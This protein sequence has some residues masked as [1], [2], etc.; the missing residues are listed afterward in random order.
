[1]YLRGKEYKDMFAPNKIFMR[2]IV[3][4]VAALLL[5][6]CSAASTSDGTTPPNA[7]GPAVSAITVTAT[8]DS[9]NF[10]QTSTIRATVYDSS[11]GPVSGVSLVFALDQP[12][13]AFITPA[14]A[15][16]DATGLAT[17]TLT[18]RSQQ[19][20]VNVSAT[21]GT[22]T[23]ANRQVAIQSGVT[24]ATVNVTADPSTILIGAT[25]AIRAE[26]L[27]ST[28]AWVPNGT[29]VS[30][31][32]ANPTFGSMAVA[33][34]TTVSGVATA[35]FEAG[36]TPGNAAINV[37]S[38]GITNSV[39]VLINQTAPASLEFI[40]A[41]PGLIAIQGSGG[42][43]TAVVAFRVND[44]N[45]NPIPSIGVSMTLEGPGGGAYI[46]NDGTPNQINVSSNALGIAQATLRSGTVAGPATILAEITVGGVV[47]RVRSSVVS[48]GGGVPSA[49]RF[50]VAATRLNL[51]ALDKNN[52]T[53][54][55]TAYMADRFGNYNILEGT[56]VSFYS[57]PA[58]AIDTAGSVLV[59]A[60]GTAT[61][62]ARTQHPNQPAYPV[63]GGYDVGP[64]AWET[65]LLGYVNEWYGWTARVQAERGW[66]GDNTPR[67]G[68]VSVLVVTDG[69]EH[70]DDLNANG[71]YDAGIDQM[72]DTFDDPFIDYNDD[73][74]LAQNT[75]YTSSGSDP[76]EMFVD[77]NQNGTWDHKNNVWDSDK[78]IFHNFK[79][80]ITGEPEILI[81][82]V[83]EDPDTL[84]QSC[85][86]SLFNV[87]DGADPDLRAGYKR[88]RFLVADM[89]LNYPSAG[90]KVSAS[91]DKGKLL[92]EKITFEDSSEVPGKI[93][94]YAT[95]LDDDP[96]DADP[97][98][99][100][101]F[102][103][104]VEWE[105]KKIEKSIF[106]YI[107]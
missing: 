8:P 76:I 33:A 81:C 23:S 107:D 2:Q 55:V 59:G 13:L 73:I 36:S 96:G 34:A 77:A 28:G 25:S 30:F 91:A 24:A 90:T 10:S 98:K 5:L 63:P 84:V 99:L 48:I 104:T 64:E 82:P 65:T 101:E 89:N 49:G 41:T 9:V 27:D 68:L 95:L 6:G 62:T 21:D 42:V 100:V 70:F 85:E 53:T 37:S 61:V 72:V 44:Q 86:T 80:L 67:D 92:S 66:A 4:I 16:T 15:T 17:A 56:T 51:P 94:Y 105:G 50:S 69:E 22:T 26:V 32:V 78:K 93:E 79:I 52:V 60:D 106:G 88:F 1:M 3:A 58:L 20:N 38:G 46:D 57:E 14:I 39:D 43:E 18:A 31:A 35:T 74:N 97:P 11:G 19:G 45:G 83:A 29:A 7:S 40:S 102:K 12:S 54:E 75:G 103:V 87:I 47:F 71:I